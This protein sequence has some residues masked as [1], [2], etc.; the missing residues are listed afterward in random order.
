MHFTQT[1]APDITVI[2]DFVM[3]ERL[4]CVSEREWKFRLRGYGYDVRQTDGGTI[5]RTLPAGVD[6][7]MLD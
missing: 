2:R 1:T 3:K 6:V 5:L 4:S 7:C